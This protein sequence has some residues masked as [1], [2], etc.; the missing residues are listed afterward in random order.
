MPRGIPL[1]GIKR[2]PGAK[3]ERTVGHYTSTYLG[4]SKDHSEYFRANVTLLDRRLFYI[5]TFQMEE[6]AAYPYNLAIVACGRAIKHPNDVQLLGL[7]RDL[8][9]E[10]VRRK[11]ADKGIELRPEHA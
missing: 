10:K 2:G 8:V 9:F 6:Q 4:V 5:G 1:S 11:L 7:E 3:P